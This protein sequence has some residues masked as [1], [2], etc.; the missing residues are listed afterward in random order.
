MVH[1][2]PLRRDVSLKS[3]V[4]EPIGRLSANERPGTTGQLVPERLLR[5]PAQNSPEARQ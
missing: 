3:D 1:E 4:H 5:E 2:A